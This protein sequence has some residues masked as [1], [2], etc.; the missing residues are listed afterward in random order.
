MALQERRADPGDEAAI[1]RILDDLSRAFEA[2][3]PALYARHFAEDAD[4]ENAF[5]GRAR[6]RSEI[7]AFIARVY[8]LFARSA[9]TLLETR[10]R[11]VAPDVAVAD[12]DREI[13]GQVSARGRPLPPRRVR[14]THVLRRDDGRWRIAVF[15]VADLRDASEVR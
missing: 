7:Q 10:V 6:G 3:D 8:P 12:V 13:A 5:G 1:R 14:T 4:W 15:R 11:F 9:Q 2:R